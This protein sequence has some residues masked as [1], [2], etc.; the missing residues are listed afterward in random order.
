MP[1]GYRSAL[2]PVW[3]HWLAF[4]LNQWCPGCEREVLRPR[5]PG[6]VGQRGGGPVGFQLDHVD[7]DASNGHA[8]NFQWL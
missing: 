1:A 2:P 3:V 8:L 7:G 5:R 6:S 4:R